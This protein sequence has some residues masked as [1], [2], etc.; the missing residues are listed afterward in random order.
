MQEE[1]AHR[2]VSKHVSQQLPRLVRSQSGGLLPAQA[3]PPRVGSVVHA[4]AT[5]ADIAFL[6]SK[7]NTELPREYLELLRFSNGGEGPLALP[8]LWFQP[9][10]VKDCISLCLNQDILQDSRVH[11]LR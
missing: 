1:E 9:Y 4:P 11:F 8:P 7:T 6:E 10:A 2:Q 5:D 3:D